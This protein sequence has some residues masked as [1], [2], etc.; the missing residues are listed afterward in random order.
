VQRSEYNFVNS[1]NAKETLVKYDYC[2]RDFMKFVQVKD[3]DSLL[4]IEVEKSI[5]DYVI[6]LRQKVASATL[7]ARLCSIYHFYAMNDVIL[8]KTKI[9]KYKGEFLRVKK[10]RAYTH[11]E[12]LKLLQVADVRIKIC[13]LLMASSGLRMGAIPDLKIK[14]IQENKLTVY[15][16]SNQEYYTFL[17]PE[18]S[19]FIEDY[20]NYRKR[21]GENI[22]K[23][24]YLIREQFDDLTIKEPRQI[25]KD[26]IRF[27][28]YRLLKKTGINV[29]VSMTHGF[30]KFFKTQ[31]VNSKV[32]AEV[33]AK[34]MGWKNGLTDRYYKPTEQEMFQEYEKAINN[35]TINEENRL[36]IKVQL[37]EGEKNEI[38]NLKNQVNENSS[39]LNDVL[40]LLQLNLENDLTPVGSQKWKKQIKQKKSIDKRLS[41][42]GMTTHKLLTSGVELNL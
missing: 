27:I 19:R 22:T 17:T 31:V 40:K 35:L 30:R 39:M 26:S 29:D 8:N 32:N 23:E 16:K 10:D 9:N 24:S 12:V 21:F 2:L 42:K 7:H 14:H 13:I 18:T 5:I 11:E 28:I 38:T 36:K 3:H 25:T 20:I 34:L 6:D 4:K 33:R 15:E 37:L 1:I 41:S